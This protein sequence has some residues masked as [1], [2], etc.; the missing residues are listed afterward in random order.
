[1]VL[2][3]GLRRT[4]D[5]AEPCTTFLLDD[6]EAARLVGLRHPS[7]NVQFRSMHYPE[8]VRPGTS[9]LYAAYFCDVE[10]WR[11][12]N[13]HMAEQA[14]R[15]RGGHRLH[16]LPVRHQ[17]DYN[18]AK[19]QVRDALLDILERRLPGV[20]D[21]VAVRDLSTPITHVRYTGNH[22]GT[23]LGWMPF[24]DSGETVQDEVK[25]HGPALPGLANFYMSGVWTTTGGLI[26]A[27]ASGRH[28]VQYLC[29][30]D[31]RRFTASVDDTLPPPVHVTLPVGPA[32]S[33]AAP[34]SVP[35]AQRSAA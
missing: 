1:V 23:V 35:R 26:R 17:R 32:T 22:N 11:E 28:V 30:D 2:F 9:M 12:L 16:T 8:L 33:S 7:V 3:L 21:S 24:A 6:T 20:R 10:P 13:G 14:T 25:K 31:G 4:I 29:R 34:V 19:H 15:V 5:G 18:A 27:A